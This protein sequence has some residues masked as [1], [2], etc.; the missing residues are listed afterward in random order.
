MYQAAPQITFLAELTRKRGLL[1]KLPTRFFQ[2][3]DKTLVC[4][5]SQA[6][7][8][9]TEIAVVT[10]GASADLASVVIPDGELLVLGHFCNPCFGSHKFSCSL[11][12]RLFERHA[13][14]SH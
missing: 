14:I 4:H 6:D 13:H 10:S 3:R 9:K 7:T 1:L 2:T 5:F 8:A 11:F 12:G